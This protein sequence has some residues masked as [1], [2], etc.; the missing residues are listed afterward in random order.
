MTTLEEKIVR[1]RKR[2]ELKAEMDRAAKELRQAQDR[3]MHCRKEFLDSLPDWGS[4]EMD[5]E[6]LPTEPRPKA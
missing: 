1:I 3:Y 2:R 6:L 4:D 5:E